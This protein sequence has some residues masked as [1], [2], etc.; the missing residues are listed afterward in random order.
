[1]NVWKFYNETPIKTTNL[2]STKK[3]TFQRKDNLIEIDPSN[4]QVSITADSSIL[5]FLRIL[6][7]INKSYSLLSYRDNPEIL[8]HIPNFKLNMGF[9]LHFG[10]GIEGA[11]GSTYKIDASYLSPNV[12]IAAR[13]ESATKQF[14]VNLLI[15]GPLYD[16]CSDDMKR[17]CRFVD[18]VMVK[19]SEQPLDLYTIDVNL[20]LKLNNEKKVNYANNKEKRQRYADKK[21]LFKKEIDYARSV[22]KIVLTKASF[23]ELLKTKRNNKFY[24]SWK[25]GIENYKEGNFKQAAEHFKQ[26][27]SIEPND[28]PAKTLL[29][30]FEK[31]N[32]VTPQGWKGVRE[33]TSK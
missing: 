22:T 7:K 4:I 5:S 18:C 27:L 3:Q 31:I 23:M 30:Y 17:L 26:C 9:G 1:M 21:E 16:K 29:K 10:Y 6:V 19:G 33:L 24:S 12:N 15:S 28:G 14:G 32:Y 8:K 2:S 11:I 25:S 20:D 13:L